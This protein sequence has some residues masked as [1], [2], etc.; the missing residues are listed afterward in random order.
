MSL[1]ILS[2]ELIQFM[3]AGTTE[4][5]CDVSSLHLILAVLRR[6]CRLCLQSG[7]ETLSQTV[8]AGQYW[9][10]NNRL[11]IPVYIDE[12]LRNT[13]ISLFYGFLLWRFIDIVTDIL[14]EWIYTVYISWAKLCVS[15]FD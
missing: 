9:L 5:V 7:Q 3:I 14:S 1:Y 2:L 10:T 11:L 4:F 13:F 15:C 6:L 12:L 8:H